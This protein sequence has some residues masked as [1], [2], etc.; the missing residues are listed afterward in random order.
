MLSN[1]GRYE[2]TRGSDIIG[3][4]RTHCSNIDMMRFGKTTFGSDRRD[5]KFVP[6]AKSAP[7]GCLTKSGAT[8]M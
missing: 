1:R 4:P 5:P 3:I 8:V 6:D 2:S 7:T